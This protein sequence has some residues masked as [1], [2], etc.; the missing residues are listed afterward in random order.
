MYQWILEFTYGIRLRKVSEYYNETRG[1]I[2]SGILDCGRTVDFI[3]NYK[4]GSIVDMNTEKITIPQQIWSVM[5]MKTWTMVSGPYLD[6]NQTFPWL[7]YSLKMRSTI[8]ILLYLLN[9]YDKLS[10]MLVGINKHPRLDLDIF[11]TGNSHPLGVSLPIY[12]YLRHGNTP[13][14]ESIKDD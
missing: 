1:M 6:L 12:F 4:I 2:S 11:Y 7:N 10:W 14:P 8:Q 5:K 3:N 13:I 9:K